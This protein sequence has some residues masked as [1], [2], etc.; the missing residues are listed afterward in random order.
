MSKCP[1][2]DFNKPLKDDWS[3]MGKVRPTTLHQIGWLRPSNDH[4][5]LTHTLPANS[6]SS[7][8]A[9]C[10]SNSYPQS[11]GN[12]L[13]QLSI[14][15]SIA[16]TFWNDLP[17]SWMYALRIKIILEATLVS[18]NEKF[19]STIQ[20][21]QLDN[22]VGR[23]SISCWNKS[24]QL[25]SSIGNKCSVSSISNFTLAAIFLLYID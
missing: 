3:F 8:E 11:R 2:M 13:F 15:L 21:L 16:K 14:Q 17:K 23:L 12:V 20:L 9:C 6:S 1:Q 4:A 10:F 18:H 25:D 24:W 5:L 7:Q 19:L 22:W